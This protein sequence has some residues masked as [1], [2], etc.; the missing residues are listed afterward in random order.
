MTVTE[1]INEIVSGM[2]SFKEEKVEK[3]NLLSELL[4]LQN[5]MVAITFNG[6]HA[7]NA[8]LRINNVGTHLKKLDQERGGIAHD[9]LEEFINDSKELGKAIISE[10]IGNAGEFK[11]EQSLKMIRDKKYILRNIE[12]KDDD[13]RCEIDFIVITEKVIFIVEVKNTQ[14]DVFIDER[15]NYCR[16]GATMKFDKN[17]G[18][19]MNTKEYLLRSVLRDCGYDN[20]QIASIVVFANSDIRVDNRFG[21]INTCF[22]SNLPY[23]IERYQGD[24]IYGSDDFG[25]I[26]EAIKNAACNEAYEPPINVNKFKTEFATVIAKLEGCYDDRILEDTFEETESFESCYYQC[27][28]ESEDA[29]AP[30]KGSSK[31][32]AVKALGVAGAIV[33]AAGLI[34]G[35]ICLSGRKDKKSI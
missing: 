22:L 29:D 12:L 13:C 24:C 21:Y 16:V 34:A 8:R 20:P 9:E 3:S 11:A 15:G 19:S 33:A 17:I 14:K 23:I 30:E 5:E 32:I 6:V 31:S 26:V 35:C 2:T 27:A 4:T 28:D 10:L 18:E 7:E 1:R 25:K